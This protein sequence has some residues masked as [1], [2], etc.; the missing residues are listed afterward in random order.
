MIHFN[1][2]PPLKELASLRARR[3]NRREEPDRAS[4]L[5][6]QRTPA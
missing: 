2:T 1:Y 4:R 3:Q 6:D 5:A